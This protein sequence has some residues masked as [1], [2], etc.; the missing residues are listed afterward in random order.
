MPMGSMAWGSR[1]GSP[2]NEKRD[3]WY[4]LRPGDI[5]KLMV[6]GGEMSGEL[7][8]VSLHVMDNNGCTVQT[9]TGRRREFKAVCEWCT[10]VRRV[11]G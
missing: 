5:V 1:T 9:T 11:D 2:Q 4:G 8:V 6:P 10:L 7:R 3:W